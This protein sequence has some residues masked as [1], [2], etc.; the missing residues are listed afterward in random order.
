M[1]ETKYLKCYCDHCVGRIEFPAEGIGATI[2]CP[3]CGKPTE[4]AL[5]V[6]KEKK[7]QHSAQGRKWFIA[8][9]VILGV[10]LIATVAIL[11]TAQRMMKKTRERNEAL[12]RTVLPVRTNAVSPNARPAQNVINGFAASAV[13]VDKAANSSLVYANGTLKNEADKQR[14]GVT[15]EI[16]LLDRAGK[17]IGTAKDYTAV[18]EPRSEWRFRALLVQKNVAS[19]RIASVKE[20]E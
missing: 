15:V 20:Q 7:I 18:V 16:E 13:T 9:A 1:A 19:A 10:G 17:V 11:I 2:P 4:L 3:H 12:R 8:G 6:P 5:E 14:F